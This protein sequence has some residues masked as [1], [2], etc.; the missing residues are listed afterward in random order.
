MYFDETFYLRQ[1][2]FYHYELVHFLKF[3]SLFFNVTPYI[4][5][6]EYIHL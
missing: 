1:T 5:V 6:T 2:N 3:Y 4:R